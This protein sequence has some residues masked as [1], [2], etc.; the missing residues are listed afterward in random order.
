MLLVTPVLPMLDVKVAAMQGALTSNLGHAATF[1][2][3]HTMPTDLHQLDVCVSL[4]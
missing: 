4:K 1:S 2:L 3:L